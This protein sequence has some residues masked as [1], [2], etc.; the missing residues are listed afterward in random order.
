MVSTM[1]DLFM[2]LDCP[3]AVA[4]CLKDQKQRE[5]GGFGTFEVVETPQVQ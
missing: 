5:E 2:Y 3:R 4:Y 1:V